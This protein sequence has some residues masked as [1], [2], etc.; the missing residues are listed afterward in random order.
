MGSK[1]MVAIFQLVLIIIFLDL[2][3]CKSLNFIKYGSNCILVFEN[4]TKCLINNGPFMQGI[5]TPQDLRAVYKNPCILTKMISFY[6]FQRIRFISSVDHYYTI[7]FNL[8]SCAGINDRPMEKSLKLIDGNAEDFH[9]LKKNVG[10]LLSRDFS[11]YVVLCSDLCNN[12]IMILANQMGYVSEFY[13]WFTFYPPSLSSKTIYPTNQIVVSSSFGQV[14]NDTFSFNVS[15]NI[16]LRFQYFT[17]LTAGAW[18]PIT[19][20]NYTKNYDF[21]YNLLNTFPISAKR[22]LLQVTVLLRPSLRSYPQFLDTSSMTCKHGLLC[23]VLD[24]YDVSKRRE[25]KPS[26]CHGFIS[27]I[28]K[29]LKKDLQIDFYIYQVEDNRYGSIINGTWNGLI[30]EVKSKKADIAANFLIMS[31]ARLKVVDF[32]ESLITNNLA[33]ASVIQESPL[34]FWNLWAFSTIPMNSWLAIIGVTLVTSIAIYL[35]ELPVCSKSNQSP[36]IETLTYTMGLLLQRDIAGSL[37][38][39][40]GSRT[41]AI[42]LAVTL[43]IIMSTYTALLTSQNITNEEKLPV[44]G[45]KDPKIMHPSANFKFGTLKNSFYSHYFEENESEKWRSIAE[46]MKSY[47]VDTHSAAYEGLSKGTLHAYIV[48]ETG[49]NF[50]WKS[51][52]YCNIGTTGAVKTNFIGFALPKGSHWTEPISNLILKYHENGKLADIRHKYHASQ[53]NKQSA[54]HPHQFDLLYLSGLCIL[55]VVG[56][57]VSFVIYLFEHIIG[58]FC[59]VNI[60]DRRA[61]YNVTDLTTSF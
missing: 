10:N 57:I 30:G 18:F 5:S 36:W 28:L 47:N 61:S 49:L 17:G 26:C 31:E 7:K 8:K 16:N 34:P 39:H 9:H 21:P 23:W 22:P 40:L 45:F 43:M 11:C 24:S 4:R 59:N 54:A 29:L 20:S 1:T 48:S 32:T 44:S 33:I 25:R 13:I 3:P 50:M 56:L 27:D 51:N 46:F 2:V 41:I 35:S 42:S 12:F 58:K 53:C 52:M 14:K 6:G 60:R 19:Y 15:S 37:P 55:L 38:H